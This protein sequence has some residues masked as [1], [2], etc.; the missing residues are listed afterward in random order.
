MIYHFSTPK[1]QILQSERQ[2]PV[3][4]ATNTMIADALATQ[5]ARWSEAMVLILFAGIFRIKQ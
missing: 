2:E 5:G 4:Q 3:Y 1:W